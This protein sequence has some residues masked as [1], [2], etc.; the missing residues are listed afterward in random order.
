MTIDL[1]WWV[2]L[3]AIFVGTVGAARL[4]R[5][6]TY[7]DFPPAVWWRIKWADWTHGTGWEKL[8]TCSWCFGFWAFGLALG[9]FVLS[10]LAPWLGWIWWIGWGTLA[11]GYIVSEIVYWDEGRPD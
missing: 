11:G 9:T 6:I 10:L 4:T 3:A 7:D 1:E 8:F 5:V 2:V